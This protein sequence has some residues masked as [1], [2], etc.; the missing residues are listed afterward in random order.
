MRLLASILFCVA[1]PAALA[2]TSDD[3]QKLID[4]AAAGNGNIKLDPHSFELLTSP[5]RTWSAAVQLTALDKRR[6]CGP[7]SEFEPSFTA[8]AKAWTKT[9]KDDRNSHFFATLDFDDAQ[10]IFQQ[11]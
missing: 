4:L 10:M 1:F 6:R 9:A 7:C 3:H 8:V 11:V 2:A 5:K